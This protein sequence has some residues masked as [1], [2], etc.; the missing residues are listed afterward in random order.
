MVW[1]FRKTGRL[2]GDLVLCLESFTGWLYQSDDAIGPLGLCCF[3][4]SADP[5][6]AEVDEA[7]FEVGYIFPI[8]P[9]RS[10]LFTLAKP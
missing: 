7:L 9:R 2:S 3:V 6:P 5:G 4:L 8:T 10:L 1:L